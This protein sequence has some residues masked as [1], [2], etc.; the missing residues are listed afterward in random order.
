MQLHLKLYMQKDGN[1]VTP[2]KQTYGGASCLQ[3]AR[4]KIFL[5][6]VELETFFFKN[7]AADHDHSSPSHPDVEWGAPQLGHWAGGTW[8]LAS[9]TEEEAGRD[10][11]R[12][13]PSAR[14]P[15]TSDTI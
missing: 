7:L 10:K 8:L 4:C 5:K 12:P 6:P 2:S 14:H 15:V 9:Y 1:L 3:S 11:P 13:G